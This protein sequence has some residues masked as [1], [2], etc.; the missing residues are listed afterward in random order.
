MLNNF[1]QY[2]N[3][4]RVYSSPELAAIL[5]EYLFQPTHNIHWFKNYFYY[6]KI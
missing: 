5:E 6:T 1:S 2:I 3:V 4:H